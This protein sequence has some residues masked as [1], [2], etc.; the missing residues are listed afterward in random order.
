VFTECGL[1]NIDTTAIVTTCIV[2][3]LCDISE[4]TRLFQK[5]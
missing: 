3:W 1:S 5:E 2:L 4:W